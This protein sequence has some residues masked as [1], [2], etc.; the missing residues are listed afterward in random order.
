MI[1]RI[2]TENTVPTLNEAKD[3]ANALGV[4]MSSI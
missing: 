3:I 4:Y 1:N 2:E